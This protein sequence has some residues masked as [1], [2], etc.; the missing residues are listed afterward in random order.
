MGEVI[1][2][3]DIVRLNPKVSS[4]DARIY[5][6][7]LRI[8]YEASDNIAEH[9]AIVQHPRTGAPIENPYLKVRSSTGAILTKMRYIRIPAEMLPGGAKAKAKK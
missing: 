3:D 6:D 7:A 5:A 4:V 9:G 1:T 8:Y 2:A